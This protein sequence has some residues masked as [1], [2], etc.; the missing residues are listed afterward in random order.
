MECSIVCACADLSEFHNPFS[1]V[2]INLLVLA[3][4]HCTDL[5]ALHCTVWSFC[6]VLIFLFYWAFC[7]TLTFLSCTELS[8]L[9][10]HFCTI[11]TFLYCTDLSALWYCLTLASFLEKSEDQYMLVIWEAAMS[12]TSNPRMLLIPKCFPIM[13]RCKVCPCLLHS[14]ISRASTF[15]EINNFEKNTC[16]I[17]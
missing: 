5:S 12:S 3:F 10:W 8:S 17:V 9:Y 6:T 14:S 1:T 2:L 11:L 7:T 4:L 16:Q 15:K 13:P